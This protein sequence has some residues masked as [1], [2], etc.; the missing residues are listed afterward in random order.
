[1]LSRSS[2]K[3]GCRR[4]CQGSGKNASREEGQ[5]QWQCEFY[6]GTCPTE[7]VPLKIKN[8]SLVESTFCVHGV[9]EF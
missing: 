5:H 4:G 1:M 8:S 3:V 7:S 6:V 9:N 2:R